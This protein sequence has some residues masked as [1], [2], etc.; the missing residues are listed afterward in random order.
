[1]SISR[2]VALEWSSF[3]AL[4]PAA[5]P[6]GIAGFLG[7]SG[8]APP[9]P[10][11]GGCDLQTMLEEDGIP[12]DPGAA[13]AEAEALSL[14]TLVAE[15]EHALMVQ[16]L[17]AMFAFP[18]NT[19][20]PD[21]P[22][23]RLKTIAI[24]EMGHLM[25]VQNVLLLVGGRGAFHLGRDSIRASNP[26][27]P[28]P[29]VLA[30]ATVGTLSKF[31][32]VEAPA[33]IPLD[34]QQQFIGVRAQGNAEAHSPLHRVGALYIALLWLFRPD[35][36]SLTLGSLTLTK[37]CMPRPWRV[38]EAKLTPEA[39]IAQYEALEDWGFGADAE[40]FLLGPVR[41]RAAAFELLHRIAMQGEGPTDQRES[42]FE[43][44]M[45]LIAA[46]D[47][48]VTAGT[49]KLVPLARSPVTAA[50]STSG[51]LSPTVIGLESTNRWAMLTNVRYEMLLLSLA[52]GLHAGSS[53]TTH[54]DLVKLAVRDMHQLARL[55][56][57]L[58]TQPTTAGGTD[59]CGPPFELPQATGIADDATAADLWGRH[60]ALLAR[61]ADLHAQIAR[62][63][64][65]PAG[66]TVL[67]GL[68]R[69]D[70][71]RRAVVARNS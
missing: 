10:A 47:G 44:F 65:N 71:S 60:A 61:A 56:G 1:V 19:G 4:A 66:L 32:V 62:D 11:G 38:D 57:Y 54:D 16:Y 40:G 30:G 55:A 34:W 43:Q 14:L 2:F 33:T 22:F 28:L 9:A 24:Q 46:V 29:L 58:I 45:A 27:N 8:V 13:S 3:K 49:L 63:A 53:G 41:T 26:D 70:E 42:H 7:E 68:A 20:L 37:D 25:S 52:H 17:Y 21:E 64:V 31:A 23:S 35:E 6:D 36:E 67:D 51:G 59:V 15:V 48:A 5:L 18:R 12:F 50:S 39:M 69:A